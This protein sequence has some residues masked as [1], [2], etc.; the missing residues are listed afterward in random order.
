MEREKSR[1]RTLKENYRKYMRVV[2]EHVI[3]WS[4]A[5]FRV[6][7]QFQIEEKLASVFRG[8]IDRCFD[9]SSKN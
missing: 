5:R 3:G 7:V 6:V 2:N 8:T 1:T 4:Y 9:A